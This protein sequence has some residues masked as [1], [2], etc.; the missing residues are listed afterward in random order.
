MGDGTIERVGDGA[1]QFSLARKD[2]AIG[3]D[4][5]GASEQH[6]SFHAGSGLGEPVEGRVHARQAVR[7]TGDELDRALGDVQAGEHVG[8]QLLPEEFELA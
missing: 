1:E 3:G 5:L 2:L 6:I 4:G 8:V 7:L